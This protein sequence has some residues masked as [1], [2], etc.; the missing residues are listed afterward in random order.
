MEQITLKHDHKEFTLP[1]VVGTENE[2]GID[3]SKLRSETGY[4]TLD[5]GYGNTGSCKSNI[6]FIDG[7]K[8]ILRYRGIPIEELALNSN[9]IEVADLLIWGSLAPREIG[10]RF[11]N[12]L[13]D[14]ALLHEGLKH[15]FE[16]FPFDA[17]PMAMLSAMVN[18]LSCYHPV[19]TKPHNPREI[20]M[21]AAILISKIRTIAAFSYKMSRGEPFI[22]PKARYSYAENLLHMMFSLPHEHYEV[23][24]EIKRAI[25]IILILHADHEQNCSTSTVRMVASS[26]ANLF[27]SISAGIAALWG[28]LHGGANQAVIEM[29]EKIHTGNLGVKKCIEMAKDKESGLRLMGFGHRVYKNFDPRAQILKELSAKVFKILKH[30]D[31]LLDIALEL[32]AVALSD[33][34]FI[35]RKLYPNI[36][37]YSGIIFRAVGVPTNMYPVFFAIGRLPGWI[38][39]WREAT[40]NNRLQI[41]RP[42]Q[43]YTGPSK[44]SYIPVDQRPVRKPL[45]GLK[46]ETL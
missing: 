24:P 38:A 34:Y 27:A 7:E 45:P 8:G 31:P 2:K 39:H 40:V 43:I 12:M 11:T 13:T 14:N 15:H 10:E 28:P 23:H 36:D 20:E 30:K 44:Q 46:I 18:A 25:D 17:H 33:P 9:F 41:A 26:G 4:I 3:I 37:F 29:L 35:E 42:R 21:A 1:V 32:E 16:G 22:Y 6:T 19:L 5:P